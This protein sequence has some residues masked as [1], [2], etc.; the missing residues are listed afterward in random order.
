MEHYW[1]YQG[2]RKRR[3]RGRGERFST[4][5]LNHNL[6][7]ATLIVGTIKCLKDIIVFQHEIF[8]HR[9]ILL[10]TSLLAAAADILESC[11][12][13]GICNLAGRK[14]NTGVQLNKVVTVPE[15]SARSPVPDNP[16]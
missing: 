5:Y 3:G 9:T 12:I 4:L 13:F 10:T 11:G 8:P 1:K 15:F 2:E 7:T 16:A 6:V 14:R